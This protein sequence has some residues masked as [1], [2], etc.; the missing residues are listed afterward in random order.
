MDLELAESA[1]D[2]AVPRRNLIGMAGAAGLAGAAAALLAGRTVVAAPEQPNRPSTADVALLE[3][4]LGLELAARD[5]YRAQLE[6]SPSG[7]LAVAVG[8]MAENHEAYAQAIAGAAGLSAQT[9]G[10]NDEV[11]DANVAA[12]EGSGFAEAAHTLEQIAVATHTELLGAYESA[13]AIELTTSILV[14]EARHA[15]VLADLLGVDDLD[16]VFGN[17]QSALELGGSA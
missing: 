16:V 7:D 15:T 11:F 10:R 3:A 1:A 17:D 13:D 2:A 9:V 8:V 6:A 5:L 4:A 14:I 12:F